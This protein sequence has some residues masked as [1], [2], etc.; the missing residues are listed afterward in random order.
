MTEVSGRFTKSRSREFTTNTPSGVLRSGRRV[1]ILTL[2]FSLLPIVLLLLSPIAIAQQNNFLGRRV[3]GVEVEVEGV[4]GTNTSEMKAL[5]D[6]SPGQFYSPVRIRDSL[7]RLH[8]SGFISG[9]RVEAE[10]SGTDGVVLRFI[11]KPQARIETVILE[12]ETRFPSAELRA[13]LNG[14]DTGDKLSAGAVTRGLGDLVS[15]YST[16]GYYQARITPEVKLDPTGARATVVYKVASGEPATVSSYTVDIRGVRLD[17]ARIDHA[18]IEGRPFSQNGLDEEIERIKRAYLDQDYLAV[19]VSSSVAADLL[20]NTVAVK[21]S[22]DSGP[23][24]RVDVQGLEVSDSQKRKIFPFYKQGGVDDFTLEEGRR[25][26]Q[27]YAQREGYFF[28]EV[29]PPSSPSLASEAAHIVYAIDTGRKYKLKDI[30]INGVDAI[31]HRTL[32][33]QMK[34]REGSFIPFSTLGRGITSDDM[35]RQDA[36][37]VMKRLRDLGYRRAHVDVLRGVSVT[38]DDL[39]I[40]FDVQQG[41][42]SR[43]EE[44][45]VR[46]NAVLTTDEL[47]QRLTINPKDPLVAN[48]V[49][50][51]VDQLLTAYTSRGFASVEV[52]PEIA[53]L[54]TAGGEDRV[55]LVFGVREGNRVRI[56][57]VETRGLTRTHP[58]RLERDFYLFKPRE[59]L[60]VDQLQETERALYETNVFSSV[61]TTSES[62]GLTTDG[63]EERHL[64]IDIAEA[65]RYDLITDFGFQTSSSDKHVPGLSFLSGV[66]GLVQLTNNNM[67]GRVYTG[68]AQFRIGQDELLGKISFLNPRPFGTH[69]PTLLSLFA[70]RLAEKT[71]RS[72]RYT[73]SIQVERR[74]SPEFITYLSYNFERI[75]VF[76]FE[77][78]VPDVE[79]NRL[80]I[81]LGRIGPSFLRDKRDNFTDPTTGTLT[82][83]SLSLASTFLGGNEQFIKTLVEHNRYYAIRKFRDTVYS[84]SARLGL[85]SPFG[86][87]ETLPVSERFFAGG[88]RDLRGFGFEEAG[89][90]D[91]VVRCQDRTIS[92]DK[93]VSMGSQLEVVSIPAGGNA[94]IVINNELRFPIWR[95]LGGAVFSDT[96]NVFRRVRDFKISDLTETLGFGFRV[97]TPIGPV[98][99][100]LGTL[101]FNRPPGAPSYKLQFSVGQTF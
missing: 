83:G 12:G 64:I 35:L 59:W 9:A 96:G 89:P 72:D 91:T 63:T 70:Q 68:A 15:F 31:P 20:N 41:P 84:V 101:V 5:L 61:T 50:R 82:L 37:L 53:E 100:D 39:I 16:H 27:E 36:N 85:A 88:P 30:E 93:C 11:V 57:S 8:D 86:N 52:V 60:R 32:E 29:T 76:D 2:T 34:S 65:K 45:G 13:R 81:R 47:R 67:F 73:A 28:A 92:V 3:V 1:R 42:R 56:R 21:I 6:V 54:G 71:F 90:R 51:N 78:S 79:R 17:F 38:G 4:A 14:L 43:I 58:D 40:T 69:Y 97:K 24:V 18:V 49:T 26:L 77:G 55:R 94:L 75:S 10:P 95:F 98:R 99:L 87:R 25:R 44:I 19:R 46:G 22:G 33:E 7:V 48:E 66:K 62:V 80:P 74:L 23:K